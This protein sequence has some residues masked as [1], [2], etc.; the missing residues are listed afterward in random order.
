MRVAAFVQARMGSTRLPG[1]SLLPIWR[2]MPLVELVLRR[3]GAA[4]SIDKV[5]LAT[6]DARADDPLAEL[7]A[8]L[9]VATFRGDELD[10]LARFEGA[11]ER[12]PAD[13]VL[14]VCADNPL[15]DPGAVDALVDFFRESQPCDYASNHT[16]ASGLPDGSG[17]E[18]LSAD[19]L[20]LA[21]ARATSQVERE[22]V[23]AFLLARPE[24]FRLAY[25][26]PPEPAWPFTRLDVDTEEDYRRMRGLVNA[27]P[28]AGAPFWD[29]PTVMAQAGA[30]ALR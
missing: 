29:V 14:R 5:V 4:R 7:A 11:L 8:V 17:T 30:F 23:P 22:H 27:L 12:H 9:G 6:S 21:C 28:E 26:P 19:A 1:K 10:V 18:I 2:E 16:A 20:R 15:V 13:A 3:V 25:A 24:D